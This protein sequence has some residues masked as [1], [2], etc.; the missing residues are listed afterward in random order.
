MIA[1]NANAQRV[2]HNTAFKSGENIRF[3]LSYQWGFFWI[4]AGEVRFTVDSMQMDGLPVYSLIC[5]GGSK[6]SFEWLFEVREDFRSMIRA[7]NLIPL[8][9][10]RSSREM[11]FKKYNHI[12]FDHEGGKVNTWVNTSAYRSSD[13]QLNFEAGVQDVISAAYHLRNYPFEDCETG[14]SLNVKT[15]IDN[16]YYDFIITFKGREIAIDAHRNKYNCLKLS[17]MLDEGTLFS[18]GESLSIW[19]TD[20]HNRIP[21]KAE[22]SILIGKVKAFLDSAENLK[23]P[24][25]NIK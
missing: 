20:D 14:D 25:Q 5:N 16:R 23:Y 8:E 10:T 15:I 4:R 11:G 1:I 6:S 24:M 17:A 2:K 21:V 22:A 7:D 12:E 3:S 18:K 13:K 19:I 9:F